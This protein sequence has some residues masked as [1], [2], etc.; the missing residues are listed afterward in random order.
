MG[1]D[2][3]IFPIYFLFDGFHSLYCNQVFIYFGLCGGLYRLIE[4][5]MLKHETQR[6]RHALDRSRQA[7]CLYHGRSYVVMLAAV[8]EHAGTRHAPMLLLLVCRILGREAPVAKTSTRL[9]A[10][11]LTY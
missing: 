11:A 9:K 2:P 6:L 4:S 10:V 8:A 1:F 7:K 5:L 3:F